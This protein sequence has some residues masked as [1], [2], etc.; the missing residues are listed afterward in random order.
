MA[1]S[2][3][4]MR[5]QTPAPDKELDKVISATCNQ[6]GDLKKTNHE[7]RTRDHCWHCLYFI[8]V[9]LNFGRS[10]L[11]KSQPFEMKAKD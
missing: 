6:I 2:G 10:T 7:L 5:K 1:Y 8:R 4:N 3:N 11:Y 9:R